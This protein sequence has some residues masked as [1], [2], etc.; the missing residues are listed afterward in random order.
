MRSWAALQRQ[1][2]AILLIAVLYE[3]WQ[4]AVARALMNKQ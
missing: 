4:G 2:G 3:I 1:K